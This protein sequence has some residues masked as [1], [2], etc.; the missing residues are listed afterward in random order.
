MLPGDFLKSYSVFVQLLVNVVCAQNS[1]SSLQFDNDVLALGRSML[2]V[3]S[4][5]PLFLR[6]GLINILEHLRDRLFH[7]RWYCFSRPFPTWVKE[8]E[9]G[10]DMFL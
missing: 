8:P 10:E 5:Q 4:T 3:N 9:M 6:Q 1:I 2:D 7:V